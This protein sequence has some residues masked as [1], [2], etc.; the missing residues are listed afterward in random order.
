LI[1]DDDAEMRD[2]LCLALE[3]RFDVV[4]A[5]NGFEAIRRLES[6]RFDALLL[7]LDMPVLDGWGV[8]REMRRRGIAVPVALVSGESDLRDIAMDLDVPEFLPKP[9]SLA[10]LRQTLARMTTPPPPRMRATSGIAQP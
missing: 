8:V 10:D 1:A 4:S 7:D 2:I 3:D 6:G 9:V 5:S